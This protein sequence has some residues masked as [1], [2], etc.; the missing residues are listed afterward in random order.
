MPQT[1]QAL[2]SSGADNA[3][4]V[5]TFLASSAVDGSHGLRPCRAISNLFAQ[6][7]GFRRV[8]GVDPDFLW[9]SAAFTTPA[10]TALGGW[11]NV[12]LNRDGSGIWHLHAH[13]SGQQS[14]SNFSMTATYTTPAGLSITQ[15]LSGMVDSDADSDLESPVSALANTISANWS[16]YRVG[17][18]SVTHAYDSPW[19]DTGGFGD[20]FTGASETYSASSDD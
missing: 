17:V 12:L 15:S 13:S 19:D 16:E 9:V 18:I 3:T 20:L 11:A 2:S 6:S 8:M 14:Y 7:P 1:L 10:G 4:S 5:R